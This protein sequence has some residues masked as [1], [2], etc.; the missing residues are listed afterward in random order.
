MSLISSII[1]K[2]LQEP[3]CPF[4]K[5]KQKKLVKRWDYGRNVKVT[6][7]L[8]ECGKLFNYYKSEKSAWTIPKLNF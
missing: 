4:C 5:S 1:R 7:Y 6:R 3:I 2:I 8:C